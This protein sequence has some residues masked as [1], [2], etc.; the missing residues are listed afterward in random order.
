[1]NAIYTADVDNHGIAPVTWNMTDR[2]T[3]VFTHAAL[4]QRG[5][6]V[7]R[8]AADDAVK[9]GVSTSGKS[10]CSG[11][12]DLTM[13]KTMLAGMAE[14]KRK[15]PEKAQQML[16]EQVGRMSWLYR[17][18]ETCGKPWVSAING[19]CMGGAFEL[20]LACHGRVV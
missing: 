12:A 20:S 19:V 3:N 16:F 11:G 9:V 1:R 10:T 5:A 2:P 6:L 4:Q 15:N 13:M 7:A 14:E 17:K 18:I 8:L